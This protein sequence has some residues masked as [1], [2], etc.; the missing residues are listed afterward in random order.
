MRHRS[1]SVV[2]AIQLGFPMEADNPIFG[3]KI[4]VCSGLCS[5]RL[6]SLKYFV[7]SRIIHALN[8]FL[9]SFDLRSHIFRVDVKFAVYHHGHPKEHFYL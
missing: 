1:G 9:T 6:R 4:R 2:I 7:I 8:E 5:F 3:F